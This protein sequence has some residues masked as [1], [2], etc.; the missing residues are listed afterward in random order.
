MDLTLIIQA[1]V[2]Y[3]GGVLI[4]RISGRRSISQMTIPQTAIMIGIGSLIIQPLTGNGT[5]ITLII[6]FVLILCLIVTEILQLKVDLAESFL[7]GKAV[8]VIENGQ[9]NEKNLKKLMLPAD[10]VEARLREA[11]IAS[12]QDVQYATIESSG[13]LGYTLKQEK[14]PATKEDIQILI[15][16]IQ[17]G[18][19]PPQQTSSSSSQKNI[20]SETIDNNSSNVPERLQ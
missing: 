2:I 11:G 4:L 12:I 16:L 9:L 18:Q 10:K 17:N 19:M 5:W 6:A 8:A 7:S 3:I 20:F 13:Q 15:Q 1:I 14:Q